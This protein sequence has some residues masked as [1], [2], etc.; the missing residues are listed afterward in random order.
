SLSGRTIVY[1]GLLTPE[2]LPRF[3]KDLTDEDYTS[4]LALVHSRFSTNTFPSWERAHP[5]RYLIYNGE[6][7]TIKGNVNCLRAREEALAYGLFPDIDKIRPIIDESGSDSAMLDNALEFLRLSGRDLA[8]AV[9]ML[10]PEPWVGDPMMD[11]DKRAFYE[12]HS[13]LMEPW[14][15]PAS[16]AFTDGVRI[17]A[18][19]DRNGLRPSRYYVTDD[20]M[21]IMASEVGVMD[22]AADRVVRKDRLRP[23]QMLLVDTSLGRII[24]DEEI[25]RTISTERPY[26]EWVR[27]H[28][29]KLGELPPAPKEAVPAVPAPDE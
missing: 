6:I 9:M 11:E 5:Y 8:H 22:V 20:D 28:L 18:C 2:Q 3:Y 26:K 12:Y 7:N 13:C 29:V 16:V 21:V 24:P 17:G 4:A 14:D 25:K 10:V 19:L 23:G 27:K 15:G 1:K